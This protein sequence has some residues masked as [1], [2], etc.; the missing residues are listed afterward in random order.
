MLIYFLSLMEGTHAQS[1]DNP[2]IPN[3]IHFTTNSSTVTPLSGN[4]FPTTF[5]SSNCT[6][7]EIGNVLFYVID[8]KV[9]DNMGGLKANLPQTGQ[10]GIIKNTIIIPDPNDCNAHLIFYT[11]SNNYTSIPSYKVT[12]IQCAKVTHTASSLTVLPDFYTI[13]DHISGQFDAAIT[14]SKPRADGSRFLYVADGGSFYKYLINNTSVSLSSTVNIANGNSNSPN[15]PTDLEL[16]PTGDKLA[17]SN[18]SFVFDSVIKWIDLDSNGD[19]LAQHS[20]FLHFAKDSYGLEFIDNDRVM[21]SAKTLV[22]STVTGGIFIYNLTM[23]GS[24]TQVSSDITFATSTLEKAL[25]GKIYAA[26]ITNGLMAINTTSPFSTSITSMVINNTSP[27]G[28][29]LPKQLDGENYNTIFSCGCQSNITITGTYTAPLTQSS[30]WIQSSNTTII[31]TGSTVKLDATP[32][33]GYV[34]LNPGFEAQIGSVF[35]AQALDGCGALVPMRTAQSP[36]KQD[37]VTTSTTQVHQ[38]DIRIFPNPMAD[39]LTIQHPTT[40]KNISLFD[41][42]GRVLESRMVNES[43]QTELSTSDLPKGVYFVSID[44]QIPQKVVK[45]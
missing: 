11:T 45:Q 28:V 6:Y 38:S 44:G 12:F 43:T 5:T 20:S 22:N 16:S 34:L 36:S 29:E 10:D 27:I 23:G 30:T 31:P 3:N 33:V 17:F 4:N 13:N 35:V 19:F 8:G 1:P 21:V 41:I 18:S 25:N 37:E 15:N 39:Y 26:S 32:T 14:I 7:N 40:I 9:F 2:L 42:Y 24:T